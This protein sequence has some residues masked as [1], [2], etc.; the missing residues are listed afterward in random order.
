MPGFPPDISNRL[1][2]GSHFTLLGLISLFFLVLLAGPVAHGS[3]QARGQ[4]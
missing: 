1:S 2:H 4:I 3:S